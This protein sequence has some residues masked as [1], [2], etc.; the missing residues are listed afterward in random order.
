MVAHCDPARRRGRL[1][2]DRAPRRRSASAPDAP[3]LP[4]ARH[5]RRRD[6]RAR[7]HARGPD[8]GPVAAGTRLGADAADDGVGARCTC[9]P[10]A[11]GSTIALLSIIGAA[12]VGLG[13]PITGF[14]AEHADASAAYWFGAGGERPRVRRRVAAD[15]RLLARS[16]PRPA[17]PAGAALDRSGLLGAAPGA[18]E[19]ER[20]GLGDVGPTLGP[21][22]RGD[23][24][25][26]PVDP[27]TS[28]ASSIRSSSSGSCAGGRS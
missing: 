22:R 14:I 27:R 11:R 8:R 6:R 28:S 18:G 23:R 2:V 4:R 10:T 24:A 9:R 26:R 1:A 25:A 15:P 7:R 13:Y 16:R 5:P 20:L 21:G 17:R 12:G 19:G 3:D